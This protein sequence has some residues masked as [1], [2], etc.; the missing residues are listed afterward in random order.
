MK[1]YDQIGNIKK[2][3]K[4][5]Y[6][7]GEYIDDEG[8]FVAELEVNPN[9]A[10]LYELISNA[11]IIESDIDEH[12]AHRIQ[13]NQLIRVILE[14]SNLINEIRNLADFEVEDEQVSNRLEAL[15]LPTEDKG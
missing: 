10:F 9:L 12:D 6:V 13:M 4:P 7:I 5:S 2:V 14:N 1:I 11:L 15:G 3:Q 8:D